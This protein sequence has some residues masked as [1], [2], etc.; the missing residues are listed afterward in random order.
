MPF[1]PRR[2]FQVLLFLRHPNTTVSLTNKTSS[3]KCTAGLQVQ[4]PLSHAPQ[5]SED[6]GT[7]MDLDPPI[8]SPSPPV[9][10]ASETDVVDPFASMDDSLFMEVD[11]GQHQHESAGGGGVF[12]STTIQGTSSVLNSPFQ[13]TAAPPLAVA[14]AV[15]A[16]GGTQSQV[17]Q[18]GGSQFDMV[19]GPT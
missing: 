1:C 9:T 11:L 18:K 7:T 12:T 3:I 13:S 4:T 15:T 2:G 19:P 14:S 6:H 17:K 16:V 10:S 8:V 5:K